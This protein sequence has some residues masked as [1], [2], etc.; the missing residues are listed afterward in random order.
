LK[1]KSKCKSIFAAFDGQI[2]N[3]EDKQGRLFRMYVCV[4]KAISEQDLLEQVKTSGPSLDEIQKACG[5]G[6]DC[7]ACQNRLKKYLAC[8][9]TPDISGSAPGLDPSL[10]KSG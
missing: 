3:P 1:L 10:K 5:A 2:R 6:T 7:G 9:P 4:C 8:C